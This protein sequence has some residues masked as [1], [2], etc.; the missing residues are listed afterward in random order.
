LVFVGGSLAPK[1]GQNILEPAALSK[2]VLF[3]PHMEDF[4]EAERLL[5][6]C[7]AGIR[8]ENVG[9]ITRHG[10]N[11]LGNP[12]FSEELGARGREAIGARAGASK[13]IARAI[14]TQHDSRSLSR[15][16]HQG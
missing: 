12:R 5:I 8:V 3:G 2:P 1:G 10:R 16:L 11:L 7:G 9:D 14:A 6:G 15:N 4:R 13:L